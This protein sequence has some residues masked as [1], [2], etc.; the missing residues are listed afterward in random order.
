MTTIYK[1]ENKQNYKW[2]KVPFVR[3]FKLNTLYPHMRPGR[4]FAITGGH[5]HIWCRS[6][7]AVFM[8]VCPVIVGRQ[9]SEVSSVG[10]SFHRRLRAAECE[11]PV[12][13]PLTCV[14][15]WWCNCRPAKNITAGRS[16][17]SVVHPVRKWCENGHVRRLMFHCRWAAKWG[18][19][20]QTPLERITSAEQSASRWGLL[21][22]F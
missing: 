16:P 19:C 7:T 20:P 17:L 14:F 1:I 3:R 21:T 6:P 4:A 5:S 13:T 8:S 10:G 2:L 11:V 22:T 9:L 15:I 18:I 12:A